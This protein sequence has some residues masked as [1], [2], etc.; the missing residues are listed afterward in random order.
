[1]EFKAEELVDR[2]IEIAGHLSEGHSLKTIAGKTGLNS[3]I[4][5]AHI[6]NMMEKLKVENMDALKALLSRVKFKRFE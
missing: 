2:E 4:L 6:R 5:A 3:K 1:M